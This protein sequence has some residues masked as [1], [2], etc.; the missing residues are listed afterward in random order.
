M[1]LQ[2]LEKRLAVVRKVS[3]GIDRDHCLLTAYIHLAYDGGSCQG[4]GGYRLDR[5]DKETKTCEGTA[6]GCDW[7][8]KVME[9]FGAEEWSDIEGE[10]VWVYTDGVGM[11]ANVIAIQSPTFD[12]GKM[13][14]VREWR[15]KWFPEESER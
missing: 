11:A 3:F 6:A 7:L 5:Y 1:N 9:V 15:S 14:D 4:F 8:L 2:G 10:I 13:F 12:T